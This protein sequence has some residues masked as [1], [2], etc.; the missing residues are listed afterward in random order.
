MVDEAVRLRT[1]ETESD[2]LGPM[3]ATK[4][5][6]DVGAPVANKAFQQAQTPEQH[7]MELFARSVAGF[8]LKGHQEGRFQKLILIVSP[9]FLGVLRKQIDPGLAPLVSLEINK[10][11][12]HCKGE[13]LRE[14][15]QA[16]QAK[17]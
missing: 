12:T 11:Y 8:L 15:I 16:H 13:E 4:S 9:Q 2:K 1:S 17:E 7:E 6:H 14:H 3:S 5:K 10:D